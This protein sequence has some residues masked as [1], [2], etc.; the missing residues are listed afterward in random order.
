CV[1]LAASY[2]NERRVRAEVGGADERHERPKEL[3]EW[4]VG[5]CDEPGVDDPEDRLHDCRR[6]ERIAHG[7]LGQ[8]KALGDRRRER[9]DVAASMLERPSSR[10]QGLD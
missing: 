5:P 2:L 6:S 1:D 8:R 3:Y 7:A 10:R 4:F 9:G